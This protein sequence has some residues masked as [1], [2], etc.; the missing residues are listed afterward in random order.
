MDRRAGLGGWDAKRKQGSRRDDAKSHPE[1]S[2]HELRE[3][4]YSYQS[5]EFKGQGELS[6]R[7]QRVGGGLALSAQSKTLFLPGT[8]RI[9]SVAIRIPDDGSRILDGECNTD[10][11]REEARGA[12]A[13]YV[14]VGS[15]RLV[16]E[17]T[18]RTP[19][20]S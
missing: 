8:L 17:R 7:P 6:D 18:A 3:K 13:D 19:I 11:G 9:W 20:A 1:R 15:L 10:F 2:V 12:A 5:E 14:F 4:A 16:A